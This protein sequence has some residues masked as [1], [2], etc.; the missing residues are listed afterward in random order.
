MHY[1]PPN[2]VLRSKASILRNSTKV[3]VSGDPQSLAKVFI[4]PDLTP[5]E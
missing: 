3:R 4:T 5:K 1:I 2:A